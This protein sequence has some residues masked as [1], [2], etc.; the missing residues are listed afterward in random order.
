M[1]TLIG[2][3]SCRMRLQRRGRRIA[4]VSGARGLFFC[5]SP[6]LFCRRVWP[7]ARENHGCVSDAA[8]WVGMCASW[9]DH[10]VEKFERKQ[11]DV[12]RQANRGLYAR[13]QGVSIRRRLCGTEAGSGKQPSRLWI[14]AS[15][16]D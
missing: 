9:R 5:G 11:K 16:S 13:S 8:C 1:K 14:T 4:K 7:C 12:Q 15:R 10:R 3:K 6:K 2:R